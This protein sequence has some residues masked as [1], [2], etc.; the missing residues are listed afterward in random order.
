MAARLLVWVDRAGTVTPVPDAP[1]LAYMSPRLSP[2][3]SVVAVSVGGNSQVATWS[4]KTRRLTQV[5]SGSGIHTF[6]IWLPNGRDLLFASTRSATVFNVYRQTADGSGAG[7]R[8]STSANNQFACDVLPDATQAL[9]VEQTSNGP[10]I[11]LIS[12]VSVPGKPNLVLANADGCRL[13]P[14]GRFLAYQSGE[15][16][17]LEVY[18]R[19][20]P[21]THSARWQVSQGGGNSAA[22]SRDGKELFYLGQS[23]VMMAARTTS[24]GTTFSVEAPRKLFDA[25]SAGVGEYLNYDVA[26]DRR[27]L[28]P[29]PDTGAAASTSSTLVVKTRVFDG[30]K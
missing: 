28:M 3:G 29:K 22:W 11:Y 19:P 20:F 8:L 14:D 12:I 26:A 24:T 9:V 10:S 21:E 13:S 23:D 1:S 27:F 16:G 30:F 2:D 18:V 4:F 15:S 17:R 5:T 7:D 25:P 6:P